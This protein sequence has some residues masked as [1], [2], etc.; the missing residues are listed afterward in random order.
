MKG[1]WVY[2][3]NIFCKNEFHYFISVESGFE[4][5]CEVHIFFYSD[6]NYLAP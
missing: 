2:F 4:N 3:N 5:L 6:A 1:M